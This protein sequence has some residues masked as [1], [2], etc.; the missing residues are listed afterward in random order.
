MVVSK[1]SPSRTVTLG[2]GGLRGFLSTICQVGLGTAVGVQQTA[3]AV[4]MERARAVENVRRF[5]SMTGS[6]VVVATYW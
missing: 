4:H 5:I 1:R 3:D 2:K 6:L